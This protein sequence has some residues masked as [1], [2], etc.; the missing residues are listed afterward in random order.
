MCDIGDCLDVTNISG[1][2]A[3]GFAEDGAGLVIDQKRQFLRLIILR[4]PCLDALPRQDMGKQ[5][6]RR[7]V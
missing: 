6:M 4:E 5:G 3:N 2:V 1:R 7:A